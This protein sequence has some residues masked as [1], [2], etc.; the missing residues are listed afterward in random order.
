MKRRLTIARSLINEPALLLLDEPTTGLDPQAR[1]LVWDRLFRLKQSGVT[2]VLTTHY[3]DEA[4]QLCDRLV[5]IDGGLIVAQ[6]SPRE[7]IAEYATR[8]VAEVR[9]GAED[10]AAAAGPDGRCGRPRGPTGPV[11]AGAG[12]PRRP[13]RGAARPAADLHRRRRAGAGN[14][15]RPRPAPAE[16][17]GAPLVAGGRL[18]AAHRPDVW[19]TDG[20]S[21]HPRSGPDGRPRPALARGRPRA[22]IRVLAHRLPPHVA[23]QCGQQFPRTAAATCSRW[24]SAWARSSTA[25]RAAAALGGVDY[26]TYI[27]PGAD[28][29][30]G[31]ADRDERVHLHRACPG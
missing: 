4:E 8:E 26:V 30:G 16:R 1:H 25:A 18:P 14:P 27:A 13:G 17:S 9:F 20:H 6:G 5:V 15:A 12:R 28:G 24:D 2:L 3:M 23:G 10:T 11:R 7:L 29:V 22:P 21:R 19:S 31:H